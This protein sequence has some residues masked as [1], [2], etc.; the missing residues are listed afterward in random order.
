MH[1]SFAILDEVLNALDGERCY[2]KVSTDRVLIEKSKTYK[3]K[4]E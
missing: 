1:Y 3:D 4:E 2:R